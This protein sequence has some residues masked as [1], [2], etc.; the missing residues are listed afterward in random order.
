MILVIFRPSRIK[1]NLNEELNIHDKGVATN[2]IEDLAMEEFMQGPGASTLWGNDAFPLFQISPPIS[3]KFSDAKGN[4]SNFTFSQKI[5]DFHP[6]KFLMTVFHLFR[7]NF[8]FSQYSFK[9]P[10]DF[11]KFTCFLHILCVFRFLPSLTTM[12]LCITQCT[13][14]TPLG[15]CHQFQEK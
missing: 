11:V 14:W 7:E 9:F 4:F 10:P 13:Y 6:Q 12:H 1:P 3:E 2:E 8:Y 15:L 5:F